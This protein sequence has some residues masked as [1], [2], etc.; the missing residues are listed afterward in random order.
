MYPLHQQENAWF[1]RLQDELHGPRLLG[2]TAAPTQDATVLGGLKPQLEECLIQAMETQNEP[3]AEAVINNEKSLAE[4]DQDLGNM[5]GIQH[6]N[7]VPATH[8]EQ[9]SN[10]AE[11]LTR[12]RNAQ[13]ALE[14]SL[15]EE[16]LNEPD[17][18]ENSGKRIRMSTPDPHVKS[19]A[20][21]EAATNAESARQVLN[22]IPE[23]VETL[24]FV[25]HSLIE[26]DFLNRLLI[27][28]QK[29]RILR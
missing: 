5:E 25:L 17:L 23:Y 2:F 16:D 3:L 24:K 22:R 21:I 20:K 11:E 7:Q 9:E 18:S 15:R 10:R 4:P 8:Q 19:E 6:H 1:S 27:S 29:H 28:R 26:T 14:S 13:S 12:K